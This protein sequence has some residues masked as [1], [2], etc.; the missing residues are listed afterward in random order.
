MPRVGA[1]RCLVHLLA[2]SSPSATP[3]QVSVQAFKGATC[4]GLGKEGSENRVEIVRK[5]AAKPETKAAATHARARAV[6]SGECV[7]GTA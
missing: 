7:D 5:L 2:R 4:R 3:K 6:G 1:K